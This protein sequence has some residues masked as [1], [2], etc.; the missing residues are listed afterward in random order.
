MT[1]GLCIKDTFVYIAS[2]FGWAIINVVDP[3]NPRMINSI[4]M[5]SSWGMS[6]V[7]TFAYIFAGYA[8]DS[9]SIWSIANPYNPYRI[10]SIY[11]RRSGYDVVV[12]SGLAYVGSKL[13]LSVIDVSDPLNPREIGFY[14]TPDYVRRVFYRSPYIYCACFSAGM[15]IFEYLPTSIKEKKEGDVSLPLFNLLQNPVFDKVV[16]RF[17]IQKGG[18]YEISIYDVLGKLVISKVL[19]VEKSQKE[20]VLKFSNLSDGVYF[21]SIREDTQKHIRKVVKIKGRR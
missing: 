4:S 14:V 10:S 6:V 1:G 21:I 11:I 16:I 19:K 17:N 20:K 15:C 3:S 9:L 5:H 13:G 2:S 18:K 8:R 12:E 7:D